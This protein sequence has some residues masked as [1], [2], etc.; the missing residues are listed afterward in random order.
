MSY[1]C[2]EGIFNNPDADLYVVHDAVSLNSSSVKIQREV[3][4][5][6]A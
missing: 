5:K 2:Y 3:E 6:L 4:Y 1:T